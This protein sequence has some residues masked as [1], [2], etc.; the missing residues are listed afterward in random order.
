MEVG[1][2][3]LVTGFEPSP[4][5][6]EASASPQMGSEAKLQKKTRLASILIPESLVISDFMSPGF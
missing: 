5:F 4:K 6:P 1:T 3:G 2:L